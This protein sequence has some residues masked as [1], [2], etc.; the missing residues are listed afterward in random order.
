M[1][2]RCVIRIACLAAGVSALAS[3]G[4]ERFAGSGPAPEY[5]GSIRPQMQMQGRWMLSSPGRGQCAVNVA[6]TLRTKRSEARV[7]HG[8]E[9]RLEAR[10]GIHEPTPVALVP[11]GTCPVSRQKAG[12][13]SGCRRDQGRQVGVGQGLVEV[14]TAQIRR[15]IGAD[16]ERARLGGP[17][18]LGHRAIGGVPNQ[19]PLGPRVLGNGTPDQ[20]RPKRRSQ[21]EPR[22]P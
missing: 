4:S 20:A 3:C 15:A 13:R 12:F 21:R 6:G 7:M 18:P 16:L 5:T 19:E 11:V 1:T 22:E 9:N 8:L 2:I 17:E 10:R 14:R